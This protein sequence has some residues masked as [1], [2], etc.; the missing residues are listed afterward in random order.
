M[1]YYVI[2]PINQTDKVSGMVLS[3]KRKKKKG[4]WN[5]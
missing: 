5:G 3:E 4:L 2:H 1:W